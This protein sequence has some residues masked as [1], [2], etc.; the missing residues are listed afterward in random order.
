MMLHRLRKET[1]PA[2]AATGT[3]LQTDRRAPRQPGIKYLL[4]SATYARIYSKQLPIAELVVELLSVVNQRK[5]F[6]YLNNIEI[7]TA[8]KLSVVQNV[9]FSIVYLLKNVFVV[10]DKVGCFYYFLVFKY[11]ALFLFPVMDDSR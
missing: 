1:P 2:P 3:S 11:M 10:I 9:H 8:T 5:R 7:N 4:R 6:G